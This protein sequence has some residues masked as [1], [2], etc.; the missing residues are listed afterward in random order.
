ME[1][2]G[3]AFFVDCNTSIKKTKIQWFRYELVVELELVN[4]RPEQ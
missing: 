3:A 2:T 4:V 1:E